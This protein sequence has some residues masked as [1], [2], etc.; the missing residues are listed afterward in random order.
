MLKKK[1]EFETKNI[2]LRI[3]VDDWKALDTY[4]RPGWTVTDQIQEAIKNYLKKIKSK[5][6]QKQ[7]S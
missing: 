7:K 5:V 2:N 6:T 1:Y 4:S 3:P